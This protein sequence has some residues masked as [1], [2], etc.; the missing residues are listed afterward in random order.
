MREQR[1]CRLLLLVL[2]ILLLAS[3]ARSSAHLDEIWLAGTDVELIRGPG[4]IRLA[5]MGN[6]T[7]A[8]EDENNEVNL[9]DFTGNVA[10]VIL[11]KDTRNADSWAGYS[12]WTDEK[13]AVRWQ[14]MGIWESGGL[15]VLRGEHY[16][17][18]GSFTTRLIDLYRVDDQYLRN[19]LRINFPTSEVA[20][21]DTAFID[22]EITSNLVEGYYAHR[23]LGKAYV[24][25]RGR[26]ALE[27][28]NKPVVFFYDM[29]SK[30]SD[31]GVDMGLVLVPLDWLQVGGSLDMGVQAIEA[32]SED[33]FHDD[34]YKRARATRSFSSH[35]LVNVLGRVRGV[36]NYRRFSFDADQTLNMNWS[37]LFVL[38]PEDVDIRRKFTISSEATTYD[39]FATRWIASDLGL[40]LS[41]SGYFDFKREEAWEHPEPNVLLWM[42]EY[43]QVRDEWNLGSGASYRIGGMATVGFEWRMNR[44]RLES[45]IPFEE[46]VLDFKAV[47]IR[48]GGEFRPLKWLALRAGYSQCNQE[49]QMGVPE[50]DFTAN[51]FSVGA[52]CYLKDDRLTVDAAFV[53]RVTK[54]DVDTGAGRETTYQALL[55]YGRFLF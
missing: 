25:V 48:S 19:I 2:T 51:A 24:G 26:A 38:N 17:G 53:N 37:D 40:P 31:L 45:R 32:A 13:D 11:D 8:V 35:A 44:G 4:T 15:V 41:V 21:P 16:A 52:G 34:L 47:D 33:S 3:P 18:G 42:D 29:S 22:N 6:L 43:D 27:G 5:G 50:N 1:S 28:D 54:P 9:Y 14:D 30:V 10:A 55:L 49:R 36:V 12:R 46:E 7:I 39:F 20:I 23:L